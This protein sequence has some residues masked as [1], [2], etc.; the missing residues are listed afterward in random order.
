METEYFEC[1]CD[2]S[3]HVLRFVIDPD[4]GD[5]WSEVYLNHWHPWYQRLWIAIK[6]VCGRKSRY[7]AF[8][9]TMLRLE[10]YPRF[11]SMLDRSAAILQASRGAL[12]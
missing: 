9:C 7:G 8:D 12:K 5:V 4:S 1:Q 2:C 6:Y 10:D 3:E 11:N